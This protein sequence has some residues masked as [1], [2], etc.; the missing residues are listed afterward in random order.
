MD[1][2]LHYTAAGR[3]ERVLILLHG[4]GEDQS[5][6]ARQIPFFAKKFRVIALDTRGHGGSPRGS[7][8]FTIA[9]F[10]RDLL[11]FMNLHSIAK[12]DL[13]G[14]SDGANIALTFA[15][16]HP[17]RVGRLILCGGNLDP[18]GVKR[19]VQIPIEIGYKIAS[20]FAKKSAKANKKAEMLGLMVNEP[21]ILPAR[22]RKLNLPV[23]VIAGTKDMI[24]ESHTRL[25]WESL[26]KSDL[27]LIKG[28][29]FVA[30]ES[31]GAFNRAVLR[32]LLRNG[33]D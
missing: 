16:D 7:A 23:L 24:R 14:F 13:L 28:S 18:S 21:H 1:V 9:Q 12:A 22:L 15:L 30:R 29:H 32:F 20:A 2:K 3:G 5:Y 6:F 8:P 17:D 11:D 27:V 25:I 19:S 31:P 26:P 33:G 4:N 10:A